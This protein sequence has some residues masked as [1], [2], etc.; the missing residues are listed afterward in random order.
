MPG[1]RN[2]TSK[3]DLAIAVAGGQSVAAW[4]REHNIPQRTAYTWA[5]APE[6]KAAVERYRIRF[7]DRAIGRL[8]KHATRA[9][10][11]IV[12]LSKGAKSEA[13][14]LAAARAVLA[15]LAAVTNHAE[16][17][18]QGADLRRR[19]AALEVL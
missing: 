19:I 9:A 5:K 15:E 18:Q 4:A 6:F 16:T 17:Q 7:V 14:K 12:K 13:V 3:T 11:E 2:C 8:A 10:D 1:P